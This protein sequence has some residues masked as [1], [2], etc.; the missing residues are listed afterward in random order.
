MADELD[1]EGVVMHQKIGR[2]RE[3]RLA[4][5]AGRPSGLAR[6]WLDGGEQRPVH[7]QLE[8]AELRQQA[9]RKSV[10]NMNFGA[11]DHMGLRQRE[12]DLVSGV[13]AVQLDLR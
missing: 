11:P 6:R 13:D 4:I 10:V 8:M 5:L 2:Y 12:V 9:W 1:G 3:L 7:E